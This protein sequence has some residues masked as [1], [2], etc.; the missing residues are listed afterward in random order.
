LLLIAMEET[1]NELNRKAANITLRKQTD[2][3]ECFKGT[4]LL[5]SLYDQ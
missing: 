4:L 2:Q 5:L 3:G 1:V